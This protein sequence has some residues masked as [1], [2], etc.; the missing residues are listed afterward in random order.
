MVAWLVSGQLCP[1]SDEPLSWPPGLGIAEDG[2]Q[3]GVVGNGGTTGNGSGGAP[4]WAVAR[5]GGAAGDDGGGVS[6]WGGR[7]RCARAEWGEER[8]AAGDGGGC[9]AT[10]LETTTASGLALSVARSL[11]LEKGVALSFFEEAD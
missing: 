11:T 5:D 10:A 3:H 7:P 9:A 4:E 1:A 2:A 8:G 6:N